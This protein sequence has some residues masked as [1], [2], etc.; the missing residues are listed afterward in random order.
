LIIT[1]VVIMFLT[2]GAYSFTDL[3]LTR[4]EAVQLSGRQ[5]QTRMMVDSGCDLTVAFLIQD[6]E[7]RLEA[8]GLFDNPARFRALPIV[9]DDNPRERGSVSIL[10]PALDDEGYLAGTR[11]GLEDESTRLNLNTLLALEGTV[12]D[13]SR[14]LLLAL[15]G[16]T[17]DVADAILDWID[18]DSEP[19][20]FGAEADYYS[21]LTPPYACKNGPLSTVEELLLIRGVTPAL[22][23]GADVNRNGVLDP[24]EAEYSTGDPTGAADR[25]WSAFLTLYGAERNAQQN[26]QLRVY[27]NQ[28]DLNVLRD[29][30]L[31]SG[32]PED[33]ANFI[34]AYRQFGPFSGNSSDPQS[35]SS[36]ALDMTKPARS[37]IGGVL[38]LID[39]KVQIT[40]Q[41]APQPVVVGSPFKGDLGLMNVF[42]PKLMDTCCVNPAPTIPGRININQATRTILAG[43]PGMDEEI[44]SEIITRRNFEP[45]AEKPG[46]RHETWILAE[47]IVTL[48]QM[49]T[50]M[51]FL[52]GGGD[53]HRAQVVGYYQGGMAA[54]RAEVIFDATTSAP[55][56]LF[57]RD[58]SHLGRGYAVETLGVDFAEAPLGGGGA[59]PGGAGP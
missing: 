23:F 34:V 16:M 12:P 46:R 9:P 47:G 11:F 55:R 20:E 10:S 54:S 35:I 57:W 33:W 5:T 44:L 21:G 27:V 17:E 24:H 32:M 39:A 4:K 52:C 15:P 42:L 41:G 14:N 59:A 40:F 36:G 1:L 43:I 31:A 25:G 2:L 22:L 56:V 37:P 28:T 45:D 48:A 30:L 53:V 3:M 38:D 58:I 51:P 7:T 18:P 13:S 29:E 8:G 49:K 6:K 50:F 26:G 19:R